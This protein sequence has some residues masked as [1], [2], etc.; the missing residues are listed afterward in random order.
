MCRI[1]IRSILSVLMVFTFLCPVF[2]H[3]IWV[4]KQDGKLIILYGHVDKNKF[5]SIEPAKIK[6]VKGFDKNGKDMRVKIEQN[7][8]SLSISPAKEVAAIELFFDGGYWVKTTEGYKNISK[9]E[10]K[11]YI[12]SMHSIKYGKSLFSWNRKFVEPFGM[13]FEIIPLKN[14]FEIKKGKVLPIKVLFEGK[15]LEG[16]SIKLSGYGK[17][18]TELVTNKNGTAD[19]VIEKAG[20]QIITARHKIPLKDNP[21]A[22]NLSLGTALTFEVK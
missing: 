11:E 16:A 13:R 21:D 4:E 17:E 6:E 5:E 20:I 2:A 12:E 18:T 22:D 10:A 14:P 9:R 7:K 1:I 15:P 19:I 8:D 3:D